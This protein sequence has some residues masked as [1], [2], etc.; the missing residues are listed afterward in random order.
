[1]TSFLFKDLVFDPVVPAPFV[2]LLALV[3]GG[4]TVWSHGR[5]ST[6]LPLGKRASLTALRLAGV[7]LVLLILL[8]PSRI[9][10]IPL[11]SRDKVTLVAIDSSRSMNQTDAGKL[12]RFDAARE[13][14]WDAGLASRA[15]ASA[16]DD[17]RLFEFA[18]N[19][20]PVTQPLAGLKADGRTTAF[21]TSITT[22]LDSLAPGE[23]GRALFLLT[24]GH[25]LELVNPAKTALAARSRGVPIYAVAFGG[26]AIVRD[27]SVRMTSFEPFSYTRQNIRLTA[28]IRPLGCPYETLNVTLLR[29]GKPVQTRPVVV[30]EEEQV[31]I[32]FDVTEPSAGQF[33][34]EI[35]V[36]P[37]PGEVD[38]SNNSATTYV[39]VIDKR[40]RVLVLEGQ[41]YWDTTFLQR[42]LRR[43]EKLDVDCVVSYAK[44]RL[45]VIRTGESPDPFKMPDTPEEWRRYD[46]VFL[47]KAIDSMLTADQLDALEDYVDKDGGVV[48]FTRA[49]AF[50]GKVND[51]LQPVKWGG[52]ARRLSSVKVARDG[53]GVPP[54]KVLA[55]AATSEPGLLPDVLGVSDA[56]DRKP[57]AATM[58][59]LDDAPVFPAM[60]HRRYGTGQVL[61][62]GVDGLW[63]WAFN[64][65]TDGAN[66]VF[67]RFWDQTVLWLL[68]GSD[69]MPQSRFTFRADTANVLLGE[70][71]HFRL[72]AR[73]K[74]GAP[75]SVPVRVE[76]NGK[77]IAALT[78][79]ASDPRD[80]KRFT[81]NFLPG[82]TGHYSAE[83][84]LP[85]G[86]AQ[87]IRFVVYN[88]NLEETDVAADPAWLRRLCEA[89]GGRLLKPEEFAP[90]LK[91][92]KAAPVE[93]SLRTCKI[94]L[95]D[96]AWLFWTIGALFGADWYLRR[97]W[98]LC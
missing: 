51:A 61:S 88:D 2:L 86:S 40:I 17:V 12:K 76:S 50:S 26:D 73:E 10:N 56:G 39:N 75:P 16:A 84:R 24:D 13:L 66:T 19:A 87:T 28:M 23:A 36:A 15:P 21:H 97:K 32:Q 60:V 82:Q 78:F 49:D 6:L 55:D 57:L 67:D 3:L 54:F 22:M 44:D 80:P 18:E 59:E 89:S 29:E 52:L 20:S 25:D 27:V 1:M 85:D 41:P 42:S 8:Q 74:P 83:A 38:T 14:I 70:E 5:T 79:A 58:A 43:D 35:R 45:R 96:R 48:V 69:F 64:A 65:K 11:E 62:V 30:H 81:A 47:G 91:S 4:L 98:G 93:P 63:R 90:T 53:G 37:L 46:L 94:T 92:L 72:A 7:A 95:W 9:E 31:P 33:E 68:A 34:Y 77:E 71:I